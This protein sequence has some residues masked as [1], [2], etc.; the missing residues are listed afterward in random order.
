MKTIW[1]L[2]W[3]VGWL[4][5][6]SGAAESALVAREWAVDGVVRKALVQVPAAAHQPLVVAPPVVFAFRGHGGGMMQALRSF[7]VHSL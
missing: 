6:R 4:A 2:W 5:L 1:I 3:V 7:R